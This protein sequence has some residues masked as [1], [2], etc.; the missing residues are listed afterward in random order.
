MFS[1]VETQKF[2]CSGSL[3]SA[4]PYHI[5]ERHFFCD[6]LIITDDKEW[7]KE[8]EVLVNGCKRSTLMRLVGYVNTDTFSMLSL[9][10][11]FKLFKILYL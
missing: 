8:E 4:E 7:D 5:G 1:S 3:R 6:V 10:N 11:S 9:K 2:S